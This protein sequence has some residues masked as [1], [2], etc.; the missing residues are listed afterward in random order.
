M[1]NLLFI[2]LSVFGL[3]TL[4]ISLL[5]SNRISGPASFDKNRA[6][7]DEFG[8]VVAQVNGQFH[9]H[10]TDHKIQPAPRA[11]DLL[12]ARRLSLALT[13]TVP[14][15]EEIRALEQV[16]AADRIEWWTSRL[17]DDRRYADYTAERFARAF[18]GTENGPF[19]VYRRRRFVSWLSDRIH[20]NKPYDE[21]V[22]TLIADE[23]LWTDSPAVN[24]VT[25]T[26]D[27][28]TTKQPDPIR[29]AARTTRAF[30]GMRI[31]CLQCHDDHLGTMQLG[32]A[33]R[34]AEGTQRDFHK[35]AAFFAEAK[36][37]TVGIRDVKN[38][39]YKYTFLNESEEVIVPPEVPYA[40]EL[41][42]DSGNRR[43]QLAGW[44]TDPDNKPFARAIV[45]R[46]W[47]M[48]F[49]RPLVEPV[50]NIPLYA[51][52]YPPGMETLADDFV[53]HGYDLQRLIRLI[54]ATEVFQ[55]DSQATFELTA[56]HEEQWAVFPLTM[57]R[58]EQM[59][60]SLIQ[61]SVLTTIDANAH[62]IAQLSRYT[63][64][65]DFIKRYGD[66]GE[67]EFLERGCTIPQR[68]IMMNGEL[69]DGRTKGNPPLSNAASRIA[70]LSPLSDQ[71]LE[72]AYL[73]ILT[74]RPTPPEAEHFAP[75]LAGKNRQE[76]IAELED[77]YWTLLNSTEFS[78][79]H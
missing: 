28:N 13:G 43:E 65:N 26:V 33:E 27:S 1:R 78:W 30:L 71:A 36:S 58:P 75:R 61:A 74:R 40:T 55:V 18:V 3:G 17:L 10:W 5:P 20:E 67:D 29:L 22:R 19:I 50:D 54:A 12:I 72:I 32:S 9:Q 73:A 16:P 62:I 57:L 37:T 60:G 45:N 23:G 66:P 49:G 53:K 8:E 21:I 7:R 56:D 59:S 51:K 34:P 64:Q 15:L 48:L 69:I 31:D 42:P 6:D 38:N 79:N 68:L 11:D 44:I 63:Q 24:F 25:V 47:A 39:D 46:V 77:I 41:K 70:V 4:A 35:L 76:R 2:A 52:S 14:S